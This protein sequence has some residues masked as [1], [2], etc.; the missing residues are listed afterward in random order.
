MSDV[1]QAIKAKQPQPSQL[2]CSIDDETDAT[3][4]G[5]LGGVGGP[6]CG[7]EVGAKTTASLT[8]K[9][10]S[11]LRRCC[12]HLLKLLF[13]T[14]GLVLLVIGYSVLGGLLF[15]LLEAPQDISKSAAIAKSREDCLRE[16]WIIT[17]KL[18]VLYERNWTMLVHEQLRRFEGSIVA[19]TRQGS[20]GSAGG[21]GAGLFHEGS[22]S[23]LGHFGY[24]AGDSQSWTFSEALLYSVT[25]ITT[26]GHG[27]LTPRTAAGKL[28]TIFYAL[29]G[30]PL[31]L[32]CLSSLG[33]LLADG[34]QCTYVR[35]CCQLQRHQEHR[36]KSTP[37]TSTPSASSAANSRE[38]DTDKRSKRRMANC[39]GC[40]YDA[41]NSETSLNDCLEYGQKGK[42][43]PDKKEGDACQLLRNLNPQQ[44][45]Y[46]QQPQQPDVMLMTT[47]SGS[48]LLKYA[49][50]QQ[51]LQQQ[52]QLSTATLPRQHHQMQLQ[53]QQHHTQQQQQLQQNFVAVP[54][55]M[56]RMPLT[57]PPNCYA[58]ATAT[59][60]F[61]FGHAPSA[62][63]SPAH[64]QAHPT[65]NPNGTALGNTALGSQPLVK[66][67]T[68]H[69]QPA[70]GKHRVLA[71]GL[72]DA[73]AVNLVTASEASTST[74]EAITLPP[75]PAYQTANV[76]AVRR[77]K[78]VT[79]P[80]PHEI[81]ALMDCGTGSP[82]LSGRHDLLPPAHSG[83]PATGAAA[84]PLLTYTA[85]ATSPQLSSGIKGGTGAPPTA[86]APMLVGGAG[87]GAAP[88]TDNGFMAAGVCGMGAAAPLPATSMGA[89]T[90][91]A[92]SAASTLSA[93]L[94]ANST[95]NVDIME[96][97]DEQE[98]ER[99]S[100]CP[101]GTPSR[102]PLIASPLSVP[103]DSSENTTRNTA[104]NRHTLQP[105]SRKT[106]LLTRRCHRH[107]SGTLYDSTANNTETSDDEEYMQ[108]GSEQF[109][110]KKL[111]YHCDGK[112]CREAE[113][114]ED[115]NEEGEGRQVPISLVLLILASYICVGTVIFALWENWSLVDGAYFCFVTLSTIGYGDFVPA[116][117][118]NGP[119]LQLYACCAYLLLGLVLVAMSFSIL[120]TQ[121][122]WKCKRIAVRLKLAR[123]DG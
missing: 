90:T 7:S 2:D 79:K 28:A 86:G 59:I 68:I 75:P 122:M 108:H 13:S 84:S 97:E 80:L 62:P 98:R 43:P 8:A 33:A 111:R 23:A 81:N 93:L 9:P 114:S 65:Q 5:G 4:F 102:V 32:M 63:G 61:P 11:S 38:K 19:A 45:F 51:Q 14:P 113:D 39:K 37:G 15:P 105:L 22:A 92:S 18:N 73:T 55:S 91:T 107:A 117:S 42:L 30:V 87:R 24:D 66:Y 76:H 40:Q 103:Q 49:P 54:S 71:S 10:R 77:A 89:A 101:H 116:R 67:H 121:L 16:L 52:Q 109:V 115:E 29:V 35:L 17:E 20:A 118:F 31:M 110:L 48:A 25:V 78:F 12:G 27:S 100:N 3:E 85:A 58:P 69:L 74:L 95:G 44:H 99:L 106:L 60:Y 88:L 57:V 112:D 41:A 56:L 21:G 36:R 46:Q 104:F 26:I 123:T 96:D 50:Q 47:T 82:D 53:Q 72:Q 70:S 120:E 34:L 119:E 64:N 83:S 6:G 94:S 1:E